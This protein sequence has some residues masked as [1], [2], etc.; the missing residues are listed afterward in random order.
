[1]EQRNNLPGQQ[2]DV[3]QV[4]GYGLVKRPLVFTMDSLLRYPLASRPAFMECGGNS[5]PFFSPTPI[6]AN[7]Q[8]L[9]GLSSC[10]EWTGV[11]LSILLDECGVDPR[12]KWFIAEG[13]DAPHLMRSVP[14][15]KG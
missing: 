7:L 5:A 11:K 10:A 14:L 15:M 3:E 13:A 1:M 6:Q 12:A 8:A 9:H 4:A 2:D